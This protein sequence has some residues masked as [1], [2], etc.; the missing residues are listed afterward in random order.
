MSNSKN[1]LVWFT[2]LAVAVLAVAYFMGQA[3]QP[4]QETGDTDVV[5]DDTDIEENT[6]EGTIVSYENVDGS[7]QFSPN[8][9]TVSQGET[10]SFVNN[11]DT[12]FWPA[13]AM[14]PTHTVYP[15]S[16]IVNCN[17]E[18]LTDMFDACRSLSPGMH[19]TFTFNET[20]TWGYHDHLNSSATGQVIVTGE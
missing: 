7:Y 9:V 14:H 12:D 16:D 1:Y 3:G 13:T 6:P 18:P 17:V 20:G 10:V 15:G 5:T 11:S 19:F 4:S 8:P 2:V